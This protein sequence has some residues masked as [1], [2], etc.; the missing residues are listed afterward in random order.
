M[1]SQIGGK[2]PANVMLARVYLQRR[3]GSDK[4]IRYNFLQAHLLST[5]VSFV[6]VACQH[7]KVQLYRHLLYSFISSNFPSY[8]T[9]AT[10]NY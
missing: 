1:G 7:L 2:T 9:N 3:P 4:L 5:G 8:V 10:V 6:Q